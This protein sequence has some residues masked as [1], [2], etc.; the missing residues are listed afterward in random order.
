VL[1]LTATP[2]PRSVAMTVFGDLEVSTLAELPGGRPQVQT[3]VVD[4]R[5]HPAWVDRAW[6]RIREEVAGGRQVFVVAPRIGRAGDADGGVAHL[7]DMLGSGPLAGLRL[8]MLH[9]Q[10]TA[11]EKDRVMGDFARGALDVLVATTIIEVGVDVPNATMM[12]I[13]DADRFGISQLHQLRGRIGRGEHAAVCLLVSQAD[14]DAP[15]WDRLRA[16]AGTRDGFALADLDLAQRREGDVLGSEQAGGRSSLRLL[17]VLE[18]GEVIGRARAVAERA[19]A[20][21]PQR[22]V[23]GFADAVTYTER[24]SEGDWLER[25]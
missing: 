1:V 7:F 18:H 25:S 20:A 9:G 13:W 23:P 6:E 17:R 10:L 15:S 5:Q 8:G 4:A 14:E 19:V 2:I 16:V 22:A 3:T 21:D 11:D 24:L 12:V